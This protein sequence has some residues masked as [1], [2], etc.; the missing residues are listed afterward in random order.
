MKVIGF[1]A[2][3][4]NGKTT[5]IEHLIPLLTGC[6]LRVSVIKHAHHGVD[7]DDSGKDSGRHRRAGALEVLVA[8]GPAADLHAA[9]GQLADCDVVL[10]EGFRHASIPKIEVHFVA[11]GTPWLF[12]GDPHVVALA[13]DA[14][15]AAGLPVFGLNAHAAIADFLIGHLGLA[16]CIS[17]AK[18]G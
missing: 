4:G 1:A 9:I 3:S 13:T 7:A 12:P 18:R 11:A 6:G 16:G 15:V 10:V 17:P 2:Y 14:D 5:L 8:V